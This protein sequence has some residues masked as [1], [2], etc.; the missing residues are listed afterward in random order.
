MNKKIIYILLG[1]FVAGFLLYGLA[2]VWRESNTEPAAAPQ[3]ILVKSKTLPVEVNNFL[4]TPK[5][6]LIYGAILA[7]NNW[8]KI[9]YFSKD[10]GFIITLKQKSLRNAQILAE[11]EFLRQMGIDKIN[12]CQLKAI[13]TVPQDVDEQKAVKDY[14]LSFCEN[15][16]LFN[17]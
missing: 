8:Y 9:I 11:E 14:S 16:A 13:I 10:E 7:E 6:K 12:A 17:N 4:N 5:E 15:G 3:K 1:I 2:S